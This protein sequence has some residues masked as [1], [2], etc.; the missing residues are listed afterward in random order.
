MEILSNIILGL[1]VSDARS[2][3]Y[4]LSRYLKQASTYDEYKKDIF[5]DGSRSYPSEQ[6]MA[7]TW[8]AVSE[9]E[10]AEN[11]RISDFEFETYIKWSDLVDSLE[12]SLDPAPSIDEVAKAFEFSDLLILPKVNTTK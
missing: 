8:A 1:S 3:L 12:S 2:T 6:V 5:E 4:Y 7:L 10:K 11:C 9:I